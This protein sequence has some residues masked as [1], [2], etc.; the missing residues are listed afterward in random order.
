MSEPSD[1][2]KSARGGM[3]D[4]GRAGFGMGASGDVRAHDGARGP[5]ERRAW[6][7]VLPVE[8]DDLLNDEALNGDALQRLSARLDSMEGSC[9]EPVD[10]A[11]GDL[12]TPAGGP[13]TP[14]TAEAA[15]DKDAA[16]FDAFGSDNDSWIGD[17]LEIE[18]DLAANP[19][20]ARDAE[21]SFVMRRERA[22]DRTSPEQTAPEQEVLSLAGLEADAGEPAG[23]SEPAGRDEP[24]DAPQATA[25]PA[26][27]LTLD[28]PIDLDFD[29]AA[30]AAAEGGPD[31]GAAD[32]TPLTLDQALSAPD[33]PSLEDLSP[34]DGAQDDLTPDRPAWGDPA[35]AADASARASDDHDRESLILPDA[36]VADPA[37]DALAGDDVAEDGFPNESLAEADESDEAVGEPDPAEAEQVESERVEAER[38]E[39]VP[40][41]AVLAGDDHAG[42]G[43]AFEE[44]A[45]AHA[46]AGIADDA[47]PAAGERAAETDTETDAVMDSAPTDG[48]DH[49]EAAIPSARVTPDNASAPDAVPT[50]VSA[51]SDEPVGEAFGPAEEATTDAETEGLSPEA[52]EGRVGFGPDETAPGAMIAAEAETDNETP[53]DNEDQTDDEQ[54]VDDGDLVDDADPVRGADGVE[55]EI[56]TAEIAT[57]EVEK[58][59]AAEVEGAEADAADTRAADAQDAGGH[60][61]ASGDAPAA[62]QGAPAGEGH[63]DSGADSEVAARQD[64]D[65]APPE[66]PLIPAGL[67][68]A[69][70]SRPA[71]SAPEHGA[72][73]VTLVRAMLGARGGR[74]RAPQTEDAGVAPDAEEPLARRQ[75]REPADPAPADQGGAVDEDR[76]F[77]ESNSIGAL[78]I[79]ARVTKGFHD[80][81]SVEREIRIKARYLE[82]IEAIDP[83]GLPREAYV[84]G[85]VKTYARF[86]H[87][88]LLIGPEEAYEKFRKELN[89]KLAAL[90]R[91]VIAPPRTPDRGPQDR[92]GA[93]R[94][95]QMPTPSASDRIAAEAAR[96]RGAMEARGPVEGRALDPM[97]AL[98]KAAAGDSRGSLSKNPKATRQA[99]G[100]IAGRIA[101]ARAQ[102]KRSVVEGAAQEPFFVRYA[103]ALAAAALVALMG[104][105]GFALWSVIA[106]A[107]RVAPVAG[108]ESRTLRV[109][110]RRG[111]AFDRPAAVERPSPA[112]YA[113]GAALTT[114]Y[115]NDGSPA[116]T[117]AAPAIV[118]VVDRAAD[119][120][121][122][123]DA[124]SANAPDAAGAPQPSPAPRP[125]PP[126][127][128]P[129]AQADAQADAQ[130]DGQATRSVDRPEPL[131]RPSGPAFGIYAI[132]D[133]WLRVR[134]R[135]GRELLSGI[136]A[137]GATAALPADRGALEIRAGNAGGVAF[138]VE[139]RRFGPV[140][141]KG[142]VQQ[143]WI[144]PGRIAEQYPAWTP[145]GG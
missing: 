137:A 15:R 109:V 126:A 93:V 35:P 80:L 68:G 51:A 113:D 75:L 7:R 29:A 16:P 72:V 55:A 140:G 42:P 116:P 21:A 107:Q 22:P 115:Q 69:R 28:A 23:R 92:S 62:E 89:V 39:S 77:I 81:K 125:T 141:Q 82:A 11:K 48:V 139:G 57:A 50:P 38:V 44:A 14:E 98:R 53:T 26:T 54:P 34:E 25:L 127:A 59:I 41:E 4:E 66:R 60:A 134:D 144:G 90:G 84:P 17:P 78:L 64:A 37:R 142:Q 67:G 70:A 3:P 133:T 61:A 128:Q 121:P 145:P 95:R 40:L 138:V 102:A 124:V 33:G 76:A 56:A 112:A 20:A 32:E 101:R 18:A 94:A 117:A 30:L 46:A 100:D 63:D 114:L 47:D 97:G 131:Q 123:T 91:P 5:V 110:E 58:G 129:E 12:G 10:G 103:P 88:E 105:V 85:Y 6:R 65:G 83:E 45:D 36:D 27:S 86:L 122:A 13:E 52:A 24:S 136:L 104:G 31:A 8:T 9:R 135:R 132:E 74:D 19:P 73:P 143:L 43:G 49:G 111:D 1:G 79:G 2:D 71:R 120:A 87:S 106:D 118:T 108:V 96:Q 119:A 99:A 130:T